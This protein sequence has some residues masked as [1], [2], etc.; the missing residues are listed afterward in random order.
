MEKMDIKQ[1]RNITLKI[2]PLSTN[3]LYTGRRWKTDE[4]R[5]Y[6]RLIH[7]ELNSRKTRLIVDDKAKLFLLMI[8]GV[9]NAGADLTN[10]VKGFEDI[11]SKH[12]GFNDNRT[13]R[14]YLV[15]EKVKKGKEFIEFNI[16]DNSKIDVHIVYN[17]K[18]AGKIKIV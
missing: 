3:A 11:I 1:V 6:S 18:E 8:V 15:K 17:D 12:Y 16:F 13:L 10:T 2:K 4:Y 7:A 5:K 14:S 9:S